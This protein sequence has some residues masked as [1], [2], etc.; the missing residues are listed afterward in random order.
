MNHCFL[1]TCLH[2]LF[3]CLQKLILLQK[4]KQYVEEKSSSSGFYVPFLHASCISRDPDKETAALYAETSEVNKT[5]RVSVAGGHARQVEL[6]ALFFVEACTIVVRFEKHMSFLSHQ[7]VRK[8][9]S[10]WLFH[11]NKQHHQQE[12][13]ERM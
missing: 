10:S 13:T 8:R 2:N 4:F 9:V 7:N 6:C 11:Q 1:F 5:I 3:F 12:E